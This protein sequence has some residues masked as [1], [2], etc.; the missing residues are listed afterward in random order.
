MSGSLTPPV[1]LGEPRPNPK[2]AAGCD[3]CRALVHQRQLAEAR[4]SQSQI[5]ALNAELRNH[6]KH[7]GQ[8]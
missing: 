1:Q 2:P 8:R 7:A 6:P 4:G 5:T 3:V